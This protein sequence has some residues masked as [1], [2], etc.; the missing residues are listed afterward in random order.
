VTEIIRHLMN[1]S[2]DELILLSRLCL[3]LAGEKYDIATRLE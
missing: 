3:A 2:K 1:L